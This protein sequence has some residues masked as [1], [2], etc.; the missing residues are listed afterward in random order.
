MD[1]RMLAEEKFN[2]FLMVVC[3]EGTPQLLLSLIPKFMI[4]VHCEAP[5]PLGMKMQPLSQSLDVRIC[6]FERPSP[7]YYS[8]H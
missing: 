5:L 6:T 1:H 4:G 2:G 7:N 3:R 8:L